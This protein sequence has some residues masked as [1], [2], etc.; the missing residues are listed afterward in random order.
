MSKKQLREHKQENQ[1]R[2][3]E[4]LKEKDPNG[5]RNAIWFYGG[6]IQD[7]KYSVKPNE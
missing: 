2:K 4:I 1:R 7:G 6:L 5:K 3:L